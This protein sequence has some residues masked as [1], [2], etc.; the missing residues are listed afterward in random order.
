MNVI[1]TANGE[2][3]RVQMI[4]TIDAENNIS[5]YASAEE[6]A[7]AST[8]AVD[9]FQN[10]KGL[11]ALAAGWPVERI[12]AVWNS[13]PG[14][15]SV[16]GFK[17]TKAGVARI[18]E[19]IQRLGEPAKPAKTPKTTKKPASGGKTAKNPQVKNKASKAP[20][21]RA[22]KKG[23][24]VA[25]PENPAPRDGSK[26][27]Q[28]V[29]MLQRKNGATISEIMNAMTWQRHT[30]RG[31]MAGAMKKAGYNVISFKPDGG[32]CSYRIE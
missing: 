23:R 17:S 26:T 18:W 20:S 9:T 13:L 30:V 1:D 11:A 15:Q 4:Y 25:A 24:N 21:I 22:A 32:E 5:A 31:F 27:A 2:K 28:V 14:V 3:E 29:E 16:E 8:V 6:A 10:Q 7:G 19:R 12:V